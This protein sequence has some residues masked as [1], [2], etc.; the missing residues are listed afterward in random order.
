M[1]RLA[2]C[3]LCEASCGIV[4]DVEEG[5]VRGVRGDADDPSSR[6]YVC[7]KVVGMQD[8]HDDPDR[9]RKPLLRASRG[10]D[11]REVGWD[12]ALAFAA[13]GLRRARK[14]HGPDAIAVYQGNPTAHNLSLMA[15]GQAAF[16]SLGTKNLYS[17]SSTDQVPHMRAAHEMFGHLLFMPVPDIDR[18]DHWLVVGANPIV[19][20]GSIMTAPDVKR[21]IG[22][23]KER[24]GRLVVVDPRRTE[25]AKL[26]DRHVFLRPGSDA[27]FFFGLLHVVFEE[28]LA[29]PGPWVSGV[30]TLRALSRRFAPERVAAA[31]GVS[32]DELRTIARDFAAA[33]RA[34]CYVRVGTCHQE[35]GTLV[36]WLAWSLG[37]VTGN[38]DRAGGLMWATPAADVARIATMLGLGGHGSF[39]T[40]VRGLPETGGEL[41]LAALAEEIET[42]GPGQIRALV[43]CAGNPA[44]SAPNAPRV[45]RALTT[46]DH[47]VSIDGY[48]NETTRHAHVI[49]PPCS[50]LE[51]AHYDLALNAFAVENTARWVD[52]P[53]AAPPGAKE[54][55][56]IVL[57]LV[58][59]TRLGDRAGAIAA[60]G[61]RTLRPET[62]VDLALRTGP[63][64]VGRAFGG[65][66]GG[67]ALSVAALRAQPHG[68]HLGPLVPRLP[69]MLRTPSGRV[70][71]APAAFVAEVDALEQTLDGVV[72]EL[73]L[74][75]R[76]HLRSNNS[77]LHNS[78]RLVKGPARCTL[79]LQPGRRAKARDPRRSARRRDERARAARG[80]RRALRRDDA[81]CREPAPR[82][83]T[84][85]RRHPHARRLRPR[86]RQPQR[87]HRRSAPRPPHRQRR[88]QRGA[89]HDRSRRVGRGRAPSD[90]RSCRGGLIAPRVCDYPRHLPGGRSC[91]RRL[92]SSL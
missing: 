46:L 70:E 73:V 24:G 53:V 54:D 76:R 5:R 16:R 58:L 92:V 14:A 50:P 67:R 13:E 43:T 87:H 41:P 19:S 44:L 6:G 8:L 65:S 86:R 35:H 56:D 64:G 25:T 7:P 82:V 45:D 48:L 60:R 39:H 77:W 69:A 32:A 38:L 79:L 31:T 74:V 71:L 83:G 17:A 28:G 9:L 10:D 80:D 91:V 47:M 29:R 61:A 62:V 90:P 85:S 18:T 81:R 12:E 4:V 51:R 84:R 1:Q 33:P 27:L 36:S 78:Q 2:T 21:R 11:F 15:I 72:P 52:P 68:I 40:R 23:L 37:A 26:A 75:G 49:L 20:N 59:R 55:G 89:R 66:F 63:Y 34:A 88:V 22:A 3:T 57:E 30:E 42:P